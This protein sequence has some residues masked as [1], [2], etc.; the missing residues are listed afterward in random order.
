MEIIRIKL[1]SEEPHISQ[2]LTGFCMLEFL[3]KGEYKIEI[4]SYPGSLRGA[5]VEAVYKGKKLIYDVS[6]G[7][8]D[9]SAISELLN[10]CDF[11]FKRSYS[12]EKN[13]IL[14]LKKSKK[15]H[16]LG[17]N[18]HVSCPFHP[19]DKPYWKE[20]IKG[21][22]GI[23]CNMYSNTY[24]TAQ[25]FEETPNYKK[26]G[27]RVLFATRLWEPEKSL[28]KQLNE[29]RQYINEM[30]LNI[31]RKLKKMEEIEFIGGVSDNS[32][33]RKIAS[34]LIMPE[35]MT[36]RRSYI[37]L[38]HTADICI[39]TMGLHESIGWKTGEY[40]A[41]AKAIV[42]ESLHYE[43]P[44]D[45]RKGKNYFE[46]TN[47]YDCVEAVETLIADP[48]KIYEMKRENKEYYNKYLRPDRLIKN[49][50]EKV[51]TSMNNTTE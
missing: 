51:E 13:C 14:G 12:H 18:Y 45:F 42:N 24:F 33:S 50:L 39:G 16:P 20:W 48:D 49:T 43:V 22:L 44:G 7:Y 3:N 10:Q 11:Y 21:Q 4:A 32:F 26:N 46:F 31:I 1:Y 36:N 35:K 2:I 30:R 23:E 15:M 34:E 25:R 37:K 17:F 8:Q 40:V 29:E 27:F 19:L 9:I 38:L 28:S 47:Q 6:D 5:F 41:S